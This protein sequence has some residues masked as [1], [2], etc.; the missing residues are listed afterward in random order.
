M[1]EKTTNPNSS[2]CINQKPVLFLKTG[3]E[4][5]LSTGICHAGLCTTMAI[6]CC[7]HVPLKCLFILQD[8]LI[9]DTHALSAGLWAVAGSLLFPGDREVF[10]NG[11]FGGIP[12]PSS[13]GL[14]DHSSL[15]CRLTAL[16]AE[17]VIK[18]TRLSELWYTSS[19]VHLVQP[20]LIQS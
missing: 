17:A 13:W 2:T 19:A 8:N 11:L 12:Q 9:P 14:G 10:V 4:F 1:E 6:A 16:Y 15:S 5:V 18:E 7:F 3:Q 20:M